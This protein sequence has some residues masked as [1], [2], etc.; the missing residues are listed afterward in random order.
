VGETGASMAFK[1]DSRTPG[2]ARDSPTSPGGPE[3]ER[4]REG[5]VEVEVAPPP[6]NAIFGVDS[7][8]PALDDA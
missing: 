3:R 5:E 2:A 1:M 6:G 8:L 7:P 4:G